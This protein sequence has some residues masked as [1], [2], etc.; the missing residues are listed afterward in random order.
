[1][2]SWS[3]RSVSSRNLIGRVTSRRTIS[4]PNFLI[5]LSRNQSTKSLMCHSDIIHTGTS[6]TSFIISLTFLH[7]HHRHRHPSTILQY[8]N[9]IPDNEDFSFV[10]DH[11]PCMPANCA[12]VHSSSD[13]ISGFHPGKRYKSLLFRSSK[14]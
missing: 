1:M 2:M 14:R 3:E 8:F 11:R 10:Y 4:I 5:F 7:R 13:Y 6:T 12:C 9:I